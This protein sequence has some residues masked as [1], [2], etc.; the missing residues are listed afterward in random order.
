MKKLSVS[1]RQLDISVDFESSGHS[2][3]GSP[4]QNEHQNKPHTPRANAYSDYI[5]PTSAMKGR[6]VGSPGG[7]RAGNLDEELWTIFTT[8]S[9]LGDDAES[10]TA[11]QF[12]K[13]LKDCEVVGAANTRFPGFSSAQARLFFTKWSCKN[14]LHYDAWLNCLIDIA[15]TLFPHQVCA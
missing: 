12:E 15:Q 11:W 14:V 3:G 8:Y 4:N 9:F 6:H 10:A 7:N 5:T 1:Y 13:L 2:S